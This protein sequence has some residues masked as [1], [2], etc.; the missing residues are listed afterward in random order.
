[1]KKRTIE[2]SSIVIKAQLLQYKLVN[3]NLKS[4]K[5]ISN[6]IKHSCVH[7]KRKN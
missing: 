1:M 3:L 5:L 2:E 7:L 6:K 4:V